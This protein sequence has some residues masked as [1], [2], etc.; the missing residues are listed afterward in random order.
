MA[1]AAAQQKMA[2]AAGAAAP[3]QEEVEHGPFPV[4]QL[5]VRNRLAPKP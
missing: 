3:Q 4:E 5:Q 2:A 1:S